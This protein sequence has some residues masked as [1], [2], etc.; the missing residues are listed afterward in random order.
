MVGVLAFLEMGDTN[1]M[2]VKYLGFCWNPM[3]YLGSVDEVLKQELESPFSGPYSE[4]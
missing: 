3:L 2:A 4:S 1:V